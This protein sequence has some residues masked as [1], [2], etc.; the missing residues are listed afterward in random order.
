MLSD[1]ELKVKFDI[2]SNKLQGGKFTEV[3]SEASL[4]LKKR[5]HQVFFNILSIA[6]QSIGEFHKS[7]EIMEKALKM[8]SNN[9]YFLNNMG[10]TQHKLQNFREA[11]DYFKRGLKIAPNYINILNN[12]GNLK[13]DLNFTEEAIE[14]Y[15]KSISIKDDVIETHLN[16]ANCY[17]SLGN[18]EEAINH[19]NKVLKINSKFTIAD[20]LISSMKKYQESDPHLNEMESKL[21]N[22]NLDK[23]QLSHLYFGLGKAYEDIKDF[24]K[25]FLNYQKGNKILKNISKFDINN[26]KNDFKKIKDFFS[27]KIKK[28]V[29][30]SSRKLIFIVGMPRSG[31]SLVEQIISSHKNVYGGGE[32]PF[33]SDIIKNNYFNDYE[34]INLSNKKKI[35]QLIKSSLEE[36]LR[37]ISILDSTNKDFTDKSPLNFK[38]IGF[39]K[40]IF[41]NSRIINCRRDPTDIAWSNYKNFFPDT[42]PFSNDLIDLANYYNLYEDYMRYWEKDFKDY[43]YDIQYEDLVNKPKDEIKKLLEFCN[44]DWDENCMHH[45]NNSRSIKTASAT[46]ARNPIYQSAVKSSNVYKDYI[47]DFL[48]YLKN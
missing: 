22:V 11:E 2:L 29:P 12:L 42:L 37:K 31:T 48:S 17:Q 23:D 26:E 3:I 13:K 36:Y 44:L 18:Y 4:L 43:I 46:Q 30:L 24:K 9:P 45:E 7:S 47:G 15:K 8:N 21:K 32:L 41:Q 19:F 28:E 5:P 35:N 14:S 39:I 10:T 16:I 27:V 6:Y 25:S 34:S 1:N 38:Y 33:L 40:N 20:R